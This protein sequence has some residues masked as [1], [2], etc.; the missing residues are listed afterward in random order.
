MV[1]TAAGPNTAVTK[2]ERVLQSEGLASHPL[3]LFV[4]LFTVNTA[5]P[6]I[7][8]E[9]PA[10]TVAPWCGVVSQPPGLW[11][12]MVT[13][14]PWSCSLTVKLPPPFDI[15]VNRRS[16]VSFAQ[17]LPHDPP[18]VVVSANG[19]KCCVPGPATGV[20]ITSSVTASSEMKGFIG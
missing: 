16:K 20:A 13:K 14:V 3:G 11:P 8:P 12:A 5:D 4:A 9:I 1:A 2:P 19:P 15:T 10:A 18:S 6:S 7:L 17:K